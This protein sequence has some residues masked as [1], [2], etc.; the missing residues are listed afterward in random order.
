MLG[1]SGLF[2]TKSRTYSTTFGA[3]RADRAQ[4]QREYATTDSLWPDPEDD[5]TLVLSRWGF[6]GRG[7]PPTSPA[8]VTAASPGRRER[9]NPAPG[10]DDPWT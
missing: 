8:L 6:T 10:G 1:F 2:S 7:Y 4:H 3:L 9:P 5:T